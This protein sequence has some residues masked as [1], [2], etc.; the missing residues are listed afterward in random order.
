MPAE[1]I[2]ADVEEA[3]AEA[4]WDRRFDVVLSVV[5]ELWPEDSYGQFE[6]RMDK[7]METD[8]VWDL[9]CLFAQIEEAAG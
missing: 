4:D 9:T 5:Q 7:L 8:L 2:K 3:L 6:G 1:A